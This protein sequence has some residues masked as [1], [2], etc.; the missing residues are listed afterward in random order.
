[1][2]IGT[3]FDGFA[4]PPED[5]DNASRMPRLTQRLVADGHSEA[6]I[7]KILGENAIRALRDGWGRKG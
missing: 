2:G 3:D 1:M 6:L 4:T 5:L 7:R